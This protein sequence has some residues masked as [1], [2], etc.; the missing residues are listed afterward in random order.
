MAALR[1]FHF[2]IPT[3]GNFGDKALFPVVRDAFRVLG[4][5]D[6]AGTA[7]RFTFTSA[8]A[9][10]REVD[11]AAVERINATAD[12]V[13]VGGGGLFLQDTNPNRLSGWQWKISAEVL[14]A[15]E[16]PL[17]VYAPGDNRFPGQPDFD[18]L[19]RSHVGRVLE[20]SV[21]FGLRNTGSMETMGR[22]LGER[23]RI[24]YQPCP[25]TILDHL[26]APLAGRRPDPAERTVAIQML[27][28]PRQIAAGFD[29]EAI[30][31]ATVTAA[32]ILAGRGWKVLSTPFHPDDAEV[33]RRLIAEVPGVEEVRLNGHDVGFF[34]G[35]D[36][37]SSV[38]YV[39]GGR[40]HAQMI[41][42]GVGAIPIS[43][44]LH[45]KLGYFA[46]DIGHPEFVVPVGPEGMRG[47]TP[48]GS[49]DPAEA[50]ASGDVTD[51]ARPADVRK[52][53]AEALAERMVAA[54]EDAYA[55]GS[56]LQAD[57]A[58]TRARFAEVTAENLAAISRSLGPCSGVKAVPA[59][60][61]RSHAAFVGATG[62]VLRTSEDIRAEEFHVA[63]VSES[64]E[65]AAQQSRTLARTR[66]ELTHVRRGNE[67]AQSE[68]R[69]LKA[70]S[71]ARLNLI[72]AERDEARAELARTRMDI[73]ALERE[74]TQL[75]QEVTALTGVV[76]RERE[77][78][79]A[80]RSRTAGEEARV[81]ARKLRHGVQWRAR[82]VI[83][84]LRRLGG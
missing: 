49:I 83:R 13:V 69:E 3:W 60:D 28:H 73:A 10:R 76:A 43:L 79:A 41:P 59:D 63:A 1:L 70:Q 48:G 21:F 35:I 12:A 65:V 45:A 54:L 29:A 17:I 44:D 36:V 31:E 4:G 75:G 64:E 62:G 18:E 51:G 61:G 9:L 77:A 26:Y 50:A 46:A 19:M 80:E 8:A 53:R 55:S 27:V 33:S 66:R 14:A 72:E 67:Q 34:T 22:L 42:F 25:T 32:R 74:N 30:H 82:R 37:L 5:T 6:S 71:E 16:V 78:L 56:D 15:L 84:R 20:R 38:P 58:D 24:A 39:L 40:G 68:L 81:L 52:A 11:E 47:Q 57:L 23:D 7:P 2:D